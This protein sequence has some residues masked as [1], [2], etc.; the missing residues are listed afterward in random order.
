MRKPVVYLAG[1]YTHPP[2]PIENTR[3]AL[4]VADTL[5]LYNCTPLVP[6]LTAFWHLISPKSYEAWL[7]IDRNQLAVCDALYRMP[8]ESSGA[9]RE[10]EYA[11]E[12]GIPVF[13]DGRELVNF[14]NEWDR[15]PA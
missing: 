14:L 8:G 11:H 1:P 12:L 15:R 7:E 13:A 5:L 2:D 3:K 4:L 10:V 9:D 6:H